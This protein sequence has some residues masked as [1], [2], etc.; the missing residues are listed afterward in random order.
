MF[1]DSIVGG[2]IG[3]ARQLVDE[4]VT[5][6]EEKRELDLKL[7]A[8]EM[9][10]AEKA[11][12]AR[13]VML[14]EQAS[15]IRTE[16]ASQSWLPRNVR[17]LIM[18]C[19]AWIVMWNYVVAGMLAAVGWNVPLVQGAVLPEGVWDTIQLGFAGYIGART[20]EKVVPGAL[21]A[22]RRER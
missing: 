1:W 17:P 11:L 8:L 10:F 22:W 19:M 14:Q 9:K 15:I 7:I 20:I 3:E 6:E 21:S 16:A 5:T 12:E 4:V 2:L 18:L 13:N